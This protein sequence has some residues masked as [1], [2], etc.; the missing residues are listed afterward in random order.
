[1]NRNFTIDT[2]RI[3]C[4]PFT[5]DDIDS[6]NGI[7]KTDAAVRKF[8]SF[9]SL[10]SFFARLNEYDCCPMVIYRYIPGS[11][12]LDSKM[13]GYINGYHYGSGEMLVEFFIAEEFRRNRYAAEVVHAFTNYMRLSGYFTFR[14]NV[15]EENAACIALMEHLHAVH[16]VNEDFVDEEIPGKKHMYR[17]Y[18]LTLKK[19]KRCVE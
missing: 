18:K 2:G 4:K 10:L 16:C 15:D 11:S 3:R 13:I 9:G 7:I 8:F 14:F 1:M 19:W 12:T 6:F 5:T 17:M